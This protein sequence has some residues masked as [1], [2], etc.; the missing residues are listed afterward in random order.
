MKSEH[1]I[2]I[3]DRKRIRCEGPDVFTPCNEE[4][5]T[6]FHVP[7]TAGG[8]SSV[9][10]YHYCDEHAALFRAKNTKTKP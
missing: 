6:S 2:K 1:R 10:F 9:S 8:H 3:K 7:W 4:A 5:T